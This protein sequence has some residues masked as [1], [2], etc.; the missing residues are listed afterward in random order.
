M[1]FN[2]FIA[3]ARHAKFTGKFCPA[4]LLEYIFVLVNVDDE[5]VGTR[6]HQMAS[7]SR[8]RHN[9]KHRLNRHEFVE[10]I[11]R[12]AIVRYVQSSEVRD[13]SDA[14][15]RCCKEMQRN[16]PAECAQSSNVFRSRF[17]YVEPTDTSL[18]KY[19]ASLVRRSPSPPGLA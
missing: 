16:L 17:C 9:Q 19:E 7:L 11:V 1:T 4:S 13:V 18:H 2:G 14:I 6:L 5:K 10:A 8:D 15:E 12:L 3:F